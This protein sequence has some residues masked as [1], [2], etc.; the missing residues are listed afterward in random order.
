MEKGKKDSIVYYIVFNVIN[1]NACTSF[2]SVCFS[3]STTSSGNA[4]QPHVLEVM[5]MRAFINFLFE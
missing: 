5:V 4:V 2:A 1:C 3:D